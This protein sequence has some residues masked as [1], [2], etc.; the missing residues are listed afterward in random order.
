MAENGNGKTV[1]WKWLVGVLI[2]L[3]FLIAGGFM[4]G[5]QSDVKALAKEKVDKDRYEC[6]MQRMEKKLDYI[7]ERVGR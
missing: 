4:A 6:D 2:T 5:L 1:T 3:L 7:I